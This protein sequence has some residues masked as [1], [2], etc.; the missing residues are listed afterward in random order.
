MAGE[1]TARL[2]ALA[3]EAAARLAAL[4]DEDRFDQTYCRLVEP[5]PCRHRGRLAEK[6]SGQRQR[7]RSATA[8]PIEPGHYTLMAGLIS[9]SAGMPSPS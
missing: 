1:A 9:N 6:A 8:S 2:A 7:R 3:D 5:V 4:A